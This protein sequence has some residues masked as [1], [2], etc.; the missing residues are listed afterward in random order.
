MWEGLTWVLDR[1][2]K[3][4]ESL[5]RIQNEI[6]E[7]RR[8]IA[9]TKC[10][11]EKASG[12]ATS[13][14]EEIG[15]LRRQHSEAENLLEGLSAQLKEVED[16]NQGL[17]NLLRNQASASRSATSFSL[18][19]STP[20][21]LDAAVD[22][23]T[24]ALN[25]F[26]KRVMVQYR[27][28]GGR[29]ETLG[30]AFREKRSVN[31]LK[32]E[33][34]RFGITHIIVEAL[35]WD[36]ENEDFCSGGFSGPVSRTEAR[37]LHQHEADSVLA[38]KNPLKESSGFFAYINQRH[39]VL[40]Q[41]FSG[42]IC[43]TPREAELLVNGTQELHHC[44]EMLAKEVW[45]L[46][47]LALTFSQPADIIRRVPGLELDALYEPVKGCEGPGFSNTIALVTMPGFRVGNVVISKCHAYRNPVA[48]G[49]KKASPSPVE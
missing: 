26:G 24:Q 13:Q 4:E 11:L 23:V 3:D 12:L 47:E 43:N 46:H 32:E 10:K 20:A 21:T 31:L 39:G 16:E 30:E 25:L 22:R 5:N 2:S 34:V 6:T 44:F 27:S 7:L 42:L 1:L 40:L 29:S 48:L 37:A 35:F 45:V 15:A 49:P 28:L 33:D 18:Q 14:Q 19:E 8:T 41:V 17:Q 36:F 9:D 38:S